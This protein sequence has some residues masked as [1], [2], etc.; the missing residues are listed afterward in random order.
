[1]TDLLDKMD[2]KDDSNNI[3]TI[4]EGCLSAD[5]KLKCITGQTKAL[6][7]KLREDV[8]Q[9]DNDARGI[10]LC[11]ECVALLNKMKYFQARIKTAQ[12]R[13]VQYLQTI[14]DNKNTIPHTL[15][16]VIKTKHKEFDY[17]F[18]FE[19]EEEKKELTF[20]QNIILE[21]KDIIFDQK[22]ATDDEKLLLD[23]KIENNG[24]IKEEFDNDSNFNNDTD[25]FEADLKQE[26]EE[27]ITYYQKPKK[28]VRKLKSRIKQYEQYATI[29]KI[30]SNFTKKGSSS[31]YETVFV[32]AR[33]FEEFYRQ[34][35]LHQSVKSRTMKFQCDECN[36][37][38]AKRLDYLRHKSL[39]HV[40]HQYPTNCIYCKREIL[41]ESHLEEHWKKHSPMLRCSFC[42]DLSRTKGEL[43]KH[44]NRSHTRTFTCS[45]CVLDFRTLREFS[46]HYIMAHERVTCDYCNKNVCSKRK[47]ETH[48]KKF[49]IPGHCS[50][51]NK[52]YPTYHLLERHLIRV[53]PTLVPHLTAHEASQEAR[54]CV[55]CDKHYPTVTKYRRHLQQSV[56][57]AH[58][59]RK[60]DRIPCPACDKIFSRVSYKNNHYRLVHIK[61]SKHYCELCNKYFANGYGVR[62]H[63]MHVHQKVPKPKDKICDLCGRGFSSNR[64][65]TNHRRTHT[66][67]RPF[68][69]EYCPA[70][71]AQS[72]AMKTHQKTQHKNI[73]MSS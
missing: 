61:K 38:Y 72:Y 52:D 69:C 64:I 6:F 45:S 28:R 66:G 17:N 33:E 26:N 16:L 5:R 55:E 24:I 21:Q 71:F 49:H 58:G 2:I 22:Q 57:H 14:Y 8:I 31:S 47:L 13:L 73:L 51:C 3:F 70:S 44:L 50:I 60:R 48:I 35:R 67:E 25:F 7:V 9:N 18:N 41:S 43:T 46:K 4:C 30:N 40:Q 29:S 63:I 56:A 39:N 53:H 20:E 42:G 54:Y 37:G 65:L 36:F 10:L 19:D 23:I 12:Y 11:W 34:K 59:P 27:D 68:K 15:S 32:T 62:K 1:M